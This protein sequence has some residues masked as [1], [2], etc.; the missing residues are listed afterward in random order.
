[1]WAYTKYQMVNASSKAFSIYNLHAV[2]G[3]VMTVMY[4]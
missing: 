4:V 1:M 3:K 2:L